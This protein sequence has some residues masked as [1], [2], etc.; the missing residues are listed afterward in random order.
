MYFKLWIFKRKL[1][2]GLVLRKIYNMS[3]K[4]A[5]FFFISDHREPVAKTI[6]SDDN[7]WSSNPALAVVYTNFNADPS[8]KPDFTHC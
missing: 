6:S 3:R 1:D 2:R 7:L 8:N 5:A 4:N